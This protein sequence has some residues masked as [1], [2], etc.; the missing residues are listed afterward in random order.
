MSDSAR[1]ETSET[2]LKYDVAAWLLAAV[3]LIFVLRL[4]LLS[5]LIAGLLIYELVH[6]MAAR[7]RIVPIARSRVVRGNLAAVALLSAA[8]AGLIAL[9]IIGLA[10]FLRS[11]AGSIASLLQ[12]MAAIVEGARASL[13]PWVADHLPDGA[14]AIRDTLAEWLRTHAA[15]VQ[16]IGT[17]AGRMLAHILIGLVI[18]ALVSLRDAAPVSESGPLAKA[19]VERA[20]R[21]G[22]AF[23]RI[24]FAQ[25]RISALNT[26]LTATYLAIVLPMLGIHLPLVKTM[27]LITFIAGLLPVLGNL[28]SNT[29]I[30]VVS[31]SLSLYAAVASLVFLVLIHKLEYFVNARIVGSQIHASAWELLLAMLTMEAAFGLPGVIAAPIYYAYVKDELGSRGLI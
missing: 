13:P 22:D 3:L 30:V 5:A 17:D 21:L 18:G 29:V 31:L 1:S 15:E 10:A 7:L 16:V 4:H 27:V 20:R 23:R 8:V 28:I 24:V 9:A 12:K 26:V 14:D 2:K 6:V 25:L 19:L 11:D